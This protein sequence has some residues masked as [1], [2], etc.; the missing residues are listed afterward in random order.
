MKRQSTIVVPDM[1][2]FVRETTD[3]GPIGA[4]WHR[5][6]KLSWRNLLKIIWFQTPHVREIINKDFSAATILLADTELINIDEPINILLSAKITDLALALGNKKLFS[7]FLRHVRNNYRARAGFET[8]NYFF[9]ITK[10]C[11]WR[12]T[13]DL[14]CNQRQRLKRH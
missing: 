13:P 7:N 5:L 4:L 8:N 2:Q 14:I 11:Q 1:D 9:L 6:T 10:L 12:I 3:F